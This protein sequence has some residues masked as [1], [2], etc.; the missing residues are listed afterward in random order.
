MKKVYT[1]TFGCQMNVY[2]LSRMVDILKLK[3][4]EETKNIKEADV[5]IINTCHIREKA[6]E[7]IFSEIGKLKNFKQKRIE[8]GEYLVIVVA[9]CVA[10]AEGNNIF[11]RAPI[12]DIVIGSESY[13][14][15]GEMIDIAFENYS[16]DKNLNL[17]DIDFKTEEK[18]ASLPKTRTV[19]SVSETLAIQS[20]CDKFCSYCVVPYTRGR[21]YSRQFKDVIYEAN[22]LADNGVKEITLF[23]QN[24]DNYSSNY[25]GRTFKLPEVVDAISQI[26]AIERIRYLSSYPSQFSDDLIYAHRDIKK[27][28]PLVYIP[29]QSGSNN[30]LK[31]MNRKYTREQY[32]ELVQKIKDNVKNAAF[33]SDFIVGFA[34]ET[35]EDFEETLDLVRIVN[36]A[37][38]F[39]FKYSPRPNTVGIKMPNQIPEEIKVERLNRLQEL[40]NKQQ[41]DFNQNSVG[42]EVIVLVENESKESNGLFFGRTEYSQAVMLDKCEFNVNLGDLVRVRVSTSNLRTLRGKVVGILVRN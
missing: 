7:K 27:L 29:V 41:I 2:D 15:I 10:K 38:S 9:G 28:M 8:A 33:S 30:V 4:Y 26:N 17:I 1:I 31:L 6:S 22:Y 42:K 36:Y 39:S 13:H 20:G 14:K 40:L 11:K 24:V 5:I 18:F 19:R 21:E 37:L 34:G 3:N 25:N 12:V 35:E 16:F 23:G 32:L